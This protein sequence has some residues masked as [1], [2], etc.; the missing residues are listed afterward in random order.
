M[1]KPHNI[2]KLE[3]PIDDYYEFYGFEKGKVWLGEKK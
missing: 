2:Y 3:K 1:K